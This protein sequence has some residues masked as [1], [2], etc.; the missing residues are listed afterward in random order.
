MRLDLFLPVHK[1]AEEGGDPTPPTVARRALRRALGKIG[2]TW[3][4]SP[5]RRISQSVCLL[6]FLVLLFY[7]CWPPGS[8]PYAEARE[9]KEFLQAETFLALDPLVSISTAL[10]ARAW[11]WSLSWAAVILLVCVVFP[12]AFCG[13]VCP[14]GTLAD[15]FDW[16]VGKRVGWFRATHRGWW[17]HLKYYVL[18][19]V[20]VAA[21]GGVLVSGLVA[22]I[23][24]VTRGMSYLLAPLQ[25][26]LLRG[27]YLV[28]PMGT[29]QYVSIALFL[30]VFALG[31]LRPRFWCRY[32]CPS[33]AVFSVA[34]LL[35]VSERKVK[36]TC[37]QC[38]R[39]V[40][41]C[42]FD[43]I[44]DDFTTRPTD[45]TFCQTCG[46]VCP[47]QAITFVG[48]W[49]T[50][51]TEAEVEPT[52]HEI[53]LS[54]RG[55]LA[56]AA[57]AVTL[58]LGVRKAF[59]AGLAASSRDLLVRPPGS[60]PEP[61]FLRMCVSCGECLQ[62]CPTNVLQP[63]GF[64]QGLEG[65][66]TPRAAADW[67][68]CEPTCNNCGQVC[69]TGA[70]RALPLEE[71]GAARMGLAVVDEQTCLPHAGRGACQL[72]VDQ[73][74][75]A[76]YNAIEFIRVGVEVDEEGM[77]IED[78]GYLA[79]VVLAEKCVGCGLCQSRC[80]GI[81]VRESG[82]LKVAAIAVVAGPGK[83]DRMMTGSYLALRQAERRKRAEEQQ[84]LLE[85]QGAT[86][87]YLPDFLR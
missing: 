66:W 68:G 51:G 61:M 39:C 32:V 62:A 44:K 7:V 84:G 43:A 12:R 27:W 48:R 86:D 8:P 31:L 47:T 81:N 21:A 73:C 38:G 72:C 14:L 15:L 46:G 53:P 9:A 74:Q 30:L 50:V 83:E 56:G 75:S 65:L 37:I 22:A 4:S 82:L 78:T 80:Y 24:V 33:G 52:I 70:I 13:Y 18:A 63:M 49:D 77:P 36:S 76:G 55:F 3:R 64:E 23:P 28:P 67:S 42:P 60:V 26:G 16:A 25:L 59:G 10:T 34:S 54:R 6:L 41:A 35:R 85:Q 17:V 40:Q 19:G 69:P 58:V 29:W 1:G 11:V 2:P 87:T 20:L 57:S 79:P 45:C 71:K 5:L